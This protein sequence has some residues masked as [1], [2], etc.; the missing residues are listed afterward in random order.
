MSYLTLGASL[1]AETW[2][3]R[4]DLHFECSFN[5]A[6]CEFLTGEFAP[7]E[8]RLLALTSRAEDSVER[9]TVACLLA[10][11]YVALQ[12][13][14]RCVVVCFE[15]LES[16]GLE[17]PRQPTAA[18]TRAAYDEIWSQLGDR[19]IEALAERP[20]STD[21]AS[22]AT[23]DVLAKF[24][25]CVQTE[26]DLNLQ[27]VILCAAVKLSLE[28]GHSD[29]S[30]YA[31][32][33]FGLCAGWRFDDFEAGLRFGRLGLA[34]VERKG[35]RRFEAIVCSALGIVTPWA[36]PFRACFELFRR[37][38]DVGDKV[39]DPVSAVSS[40]CCLVSNLLMAG[41]PL[42]EVEAEAEAA[43][44]YCRRVAFRDF[45]D[46]ADTQ[47]ALIRNLRGVTRRFG[48]F[49][50]DRFD[51]RRL[52]DHFE[53]QP[54]ARVFECWFWIRVLQARVFAGEYRAAADASSRARALLTS[55]A[56]LVE[57]VE[58]E[59]YSALAQAALCDAA[60]PVTRGLHLEALAAHQRQ[61]AEWARHC[62]ENFESRAV[63]LDAE[64]ARV[65]GRE[66]DA[67]RLFE[68]AILSAHEGGFVQ[69]EALATERAA[70]FHE[71][72]GFDKIAKTYLRD[73]R[74]CYLRWGAEG[75]VRQLDGRYPYLRG[76][77]LPADAA[78]T[79]Q[80]P[81]EYWDLATVL[82]VLQA[83]SRETD[84]ESLVATVMRL[85]IEHAGAQRGLL[86]FP[87]ADGYRIEAE[88][89]VHGTGANVV[90]RQSPLTGEDL[91]ESVFN[92]VLRT[93]ETVVLDDRSVLADLFSDDGY[94]RRQRTRSALCMP[95]LKQSRLVA[96]IYLENNLTSGV[97]T[98]ARTALLELLASE[99]AI[100]L[101]NAQL[102]REL[103]EREAR[104]RR[105]VDSN[106]IGVV[107]WHADG[108]I[109]DTNE[110]FLRIVCY[111]REELISG[112]V[113]W[114][115]L[116]PPEWRER[117]AFVLA[118]RA[119][120]RS[121]GPHE[122][123]YIRKDGS[124]VPV[125]LGGAMFDGTA[126]EGVAFVVDL[127]ERKQAEEALRAREHESREI[128]DSIPGMIAVHTAEG[129]LEFVTNQAL[130]FYG[131]PLDEL[132]RA[133]PANL[134]HPDD[135][136]LGLEAFSRA[137]A[138][139]EPY[140][141]EI[142][143][144][145]AD[146]V[147]RWLESR[148]APLR[149]AN[150]KVVRWYNLLIDIDDRKRAEQALVKSERNL[151]LTVD[152]I[153]ALAWSAHPDGTAE[154]FN[155][156]YLDYLGLSAEQA[157]GWR[158][159]DSVHPDDIHHLV[160]TWRRSMA[161]GTPGEAE[162]R[163]RR[164]DGEYRWF[165]QRANPLRDDEGNIVKWYGVNTDIEDRKRAETELRRAYDGFAE[166]QRLSKTGSFITDL[167]EEHTWSEETH[168]ILGLERGSR[169][170]M[171]TVRGVIHPDD[172]PSFESTLSARHGGSERRFRVQGRDSP[173]HREA[174]AW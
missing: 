52:Q 27:C 113:R 152:T 101:E 136:A 108:R 135:I 137:M 79:V 142:R 115:D 117:N 75:K 103:R 122:S 47:A 20:L 63:L 61:L 26:V 28:R 128:V 84:L 151:R 1:L 5:R 138:T 107:I 51:E 74:Q 2:E 24:A 125:L 89:K 67:M 72:R 30:C 171:Q 121:T 95:L 73:A 172:L 86:I 169:I 44:A 76:S 112:R 56:S 70:Y 22:R 85:A 62:P 105:L 8:A 93:S 34:L 64:L 104:V 25:R 114:T 82:K 147:Y 60:D 4:R 157:S 6:E 97:F 154:F 57:V 133:G 141:Y 58:Y 110:A 16:A 3:R 123:E 48:S 148:A 155:R 174:R 9:A 162:A 13:L 42:A 69:I 80:T 46:A 66:L 41:E 21:A 7:A 156:H 39:G 149:D 90:L 38:V 129:E 132:K 130:E 17:I 98:S 168:R 35:L 164:R 77:P 55:S 153:P 158:W 91:P 159:T 163:V 116:T 92:Y 94:L 88:A 127:T 18:E 68:R 83:V 111:E 126:D 59:L 96:V 131:K 43:L 71:A 139:G 23:L 145:R 106:V 161:S 167:Q 99:A 15:Y 165:L 146:G 109:L 31:Y 36:A 33:F 10:D 65:E 50:D 120:G 102:Y 45:I 160:T 134:C 150:G 166:A 100:S 12:R 14:D 144:L 53:T 40:C 19:P 170:T 119:E 81:L 124:R 49:D 54:H 143:G 118:A 87:R 140:V 29:S 37:A 78:R 173:G 11:V 32:A